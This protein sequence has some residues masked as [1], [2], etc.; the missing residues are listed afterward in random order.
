MAV[1]RRAG[2]VE[3]CY[4]V[5][6]LA[7]V[8]RMGG[9]FAAEGLVNRHDST[10]PRASRPPPDAGAYRLLVLFGPS[11]GIAGSSF[12]LGAERVEIGRAE[13]LGGIVLD[14]DSGA[15]RRHAVIERDSQGTSFLIRDLD[16]RNGTFVNGH[17]IKE[18]E[19]RHND[20]LRIGDHVM[21]MERLTMAEC[22]LLIAARDRD[23]VLRGESVSTRRTAMQLAKLAELGEP[24]LVLGESG[25]GKERV[26]EELHR[27]SGRG[28]A[29]VPVNCAAIPDA[30]A[31]AELFGH[32][33]GAFTGAPGGRDG[34]FAAASK[35][36]IFLDEI[37]ELPPGIQAKLLRVLATGEIRR[38]G[39]TKV[40]TVDVRIVAATHVD[41]EQAVEEGAFRGDLYSRLAAQRIRIQPLRERR[42][43]IRTLAAEVAGLVHEKLSADVAEA[44]FV[45]SWPYNVRELLQVARA[46]LHSSNG[47]TVQMSDL[48]ERFLDAVPGQVAADGPKSF[49]LPAALR[50]SRTGTPTGDELRDVLREFDGNIMRV[51]AFFG[52]DRRQIYR[53]AQRLGV[54]VTSFRDDS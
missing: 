37:G 48:P 40:R 29:L 54:D 12:G 9:G 15:S 18:I 23:S 20:V 19:L 32:A 41:L 24:V 16:S 53:W 22:E 2:I 46:A 10:V 50:V 30:L 35:G 14:G 17:R 45:Y 8:S 33:A 11:A 6:S 31:E 51:A 42:E 7:A 34:L 36:T 4:V 1:A 5:W 28:G 39:E 38:V 27:L 47:G 13:E 25:S 49:E 44:L 21:L 26:A 43:D 3:F 52:K